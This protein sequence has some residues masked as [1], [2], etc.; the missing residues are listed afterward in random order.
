M[1]EPKRRSVRMTDEEAWSFVADAHTGILTTLRRDGVPIA[2]PIWFAAIDRRIYVSTRGK[3]LARVRNDPRASF[4][5]EAG[6]RWAELQA[7]H[8]TGTARVLESVDEHLQR[9]IGEEMARKY[10]SSQTATKAMPKATREH[11]TTSSGGT[12]EFVPDERMLTWDN[13]HLGLS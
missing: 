12:I 11:Y 4:L 1:S 6:E 5:V 8:L 3:K 2:L 9:R 7:V 13:N 10:A